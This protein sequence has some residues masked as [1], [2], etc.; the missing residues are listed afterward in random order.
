MAN[1]IQILNYTAFHIM[2]IHL[3]KVWIKLFSF[4]LWVNSAWH[5]DFGMATSLGAGKLWIQSCLILLKI[6]L[7]ASWLY[8]GVGKYISHNY[9]GD[10]CNVMVII[11]VSRQGWVQIPNEAVCISHTANT[12]GK[13]MNT[14]MGKYRGRLG[15]LTLVWQLVYK[16]ENQTL[17][18]M[19]SARLFLSKTYYMSSTPD[20]GICSVHY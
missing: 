4:H 9:V 17:G 15:S 13:A 1:Q 14:V 7:V 16:K 10:T 18:W 19:H 6:D 2:L 20:Y 11:I 8:V 5:F 12:P 3:G